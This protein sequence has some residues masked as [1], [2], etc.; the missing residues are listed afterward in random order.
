MRPSASGAD[1]ERATLSQLDLVTGTAGVRDSDAPSKT[2][3]HRPKEVDRKNIWAQRRVH[4][5]N[6]QLYAIAGDVPTAVEI[7]RRLG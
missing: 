1:R 6:A 5:I 7:R 2:P 3:I 4:A